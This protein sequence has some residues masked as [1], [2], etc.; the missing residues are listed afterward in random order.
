MVF[1]N[2]RAHKN[3]W[4]INQDLMKDARHIQNNLEIAYQ[5]SRMWKQWRG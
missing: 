5:H 2:G 4:V 1:G 3:P